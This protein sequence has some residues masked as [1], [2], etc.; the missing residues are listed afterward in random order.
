MLKTKLIS[1]ATMSALA[2]GVLAPIGSVGAATESGTTAA[3]FILEHSDKLYLEKAP[4]MNFGTTTVFDLNTKNTNLSYENEN[5]TAK[6]TRATVE[7]ADPLGAKGLLV[8][9]YR[10]APTTGSNAWELSA[11]METTFTAE[12][13][14]SIESNGISS[15]TF[16]GVT[17]DM[18]NTINGDN[19]IIATNTSGITN[20]EVNPT[21]ATTLNLLQNT[22]LG[23]ND[24]NKP[25]QSNITWTLSDTLSF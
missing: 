17:G 3:E 22:E 6:N 10:E 20:N 1:L 24:I 11:S 7:V 16:D 23:N 5:V 9:D 18:G 14:T 2:V 15:L 12:G 13:A 4:D 19:T 21:N 25:Y 8:R